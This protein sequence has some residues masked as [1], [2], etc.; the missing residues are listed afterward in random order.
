MNIPT[1]DAVGPATGTPE[2]NARHVAILLHGLGEVD[3]DWLLGQLPPTQQGQLQPLLAELQV[4]GIPSDPQLTRDAVLRGTAP[5]DLS[6]PPS[7]SADAGDPALDR[8]AAAATARVLAPE[9]AT[10]AAE[11]LARGGA[12]W[13]AEVLREMAPP[14]RR[15]IEAALA[16]HLAA[17][18]L[19][20]ASLPGLRQR[21]RTLVALLERRALVL[22]TDRVGVTVVPL[23][24]PVPE[25]P[26][27]RRLR[28]AQ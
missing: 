4:L 28:R 22:G 19:P 1:F 23:V 5:P 17:V 24:R 11:L 8:L 12:A 26:W 15:E 3:R 6:P 18:S 10:L 20:G 16:P 14:R 21:E 13:R 2:G 9:P 25:R 27:W 7:R